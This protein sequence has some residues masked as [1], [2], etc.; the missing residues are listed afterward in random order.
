MNI[1]S[2]MEKWTSRSRWR[3]SLLLIALMIFPIALFSYYITGV[4]KAQVEHQGRVESTQIAGVSASLVEDHFRQSIAFLDS[5]AGRRTLRQA[6]TSGDLKM[7]RWHLSEAKR[8]RP[9]FSFVS[10]YGLDGTMRA[11]DPPQPELIGETF[12]FRDWY[13]GVSREWKPY[14]SEVYRTAVSPHDLV[15]AVVVP[16][17]DEQGKPIGILMGADPLQTISQHLVATRLE[18]G[19]NILLVDQ[20]GHLAARRDIGSPSTIVDLTEYEPVERL[21]AG[22]NGIGTFTRGNQTM[23]TRYESVPAY[24]WGVLVEQPS[25]LLQQRVWS[26]EKRVWVLGLVFAF[27]GLFISALLGS[28]YAQL[29]TGNRFMDL[30]VD[31]FCIAGFDGYFKSVNPSWGKVL[32]FSAREIT[33]RPYMEFIHPDDRGGNAKR[34][35]GFAKRRSHAGFR[36]PVFVQRRLL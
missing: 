16:L 12:A 7:V 20:K 28:L 31:M 18:G 4:L 26:V 23:F 5:I 14:V 15:V 10:V 27:G 32:G 17:Y 3:R 11:I 21:H 22:S 24:G 30:S 36:K 35:G 2:R 8:L 9:D 33:S 25:F 1:S 29:E 13:K 34:R 19:W 6:W